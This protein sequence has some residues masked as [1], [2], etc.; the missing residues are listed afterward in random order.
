MGG[1]ELRG[2]EGARLR[3]G[4]PRRRRGSL[5]LALSPRL[6]LF[7]LEGNP[8]FY[9][10]GD[11][12]F[13][14]E[15]NLIAWER[16]SEGEGEPR[17]RPSGGPRPR[18]RASGGG[19]VGGGCSPPA[20]ACSAAGTAGVT[21]AQAV[22]LRSGPGPVPGRAQVRAGPRS[23]PGPGPGRAVA[24]DSRQGQGPRGRPARPHSH[25]PC[26]R[27]NAPASMQRRDFAGW[28]VDRLSCAGGGAAC[29]NESCRRRRRL[30]IDD[31]RT[32]ST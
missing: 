24:A 7:Y 28:R 23:G 11:P 5:S 26:R 22:P 32:G 31:G 21:P 13:F 2:A 9:L 19:A 14:L 17:R 18:S 16:V 27:R 15:G 3:R 25:E 1:W 29:P 8:L 10:E 6:S 4:E 20:R 12:L 30:L